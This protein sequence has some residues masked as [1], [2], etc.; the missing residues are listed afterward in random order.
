[1]HSKG[2]YRDSDGG[3]AAF[4]NRY[5]T[6]LK[7]KKVG[8]KPFDENKSADFSLHL[9]RVLA[10]CSNDEVMLLEFVQGKV[11]ILSILR[12]VEGF[13]PGF[14]S[15]LTPWTEE[16]SRNLKKMQTTVASTSKSVTDV[17]RMTTQAEYR[18]SVLAEDAMKLRL[19]LSARAM[20]FDTLGWAC[21]GTKFHSVYLRHQQRANVMADQHGEANDNLSMS[22]F[23]E[24]FGNMPEKEVVEILMAPDHHC[25]DEST[26]EVKGSSSSVVK[27][28]R[29]VCAGV[30]GEALARQ[31]ALTNDRVGSEF[32]EPSRVDRDA[33]KRGS[34]TVGEDETV[35]GETATRG[36]TTVS[37][38][39]GDEE[40]SDQSDHTTPRFD[41]PTPRNDRRSSTAFNPSRRMGYSSSAQQRADWRALPWGTRL[42]YI[43]YLVNVTPFTMREAYE[44]PY[45]LYL[46]LLQVAIPDEHLKHSLSLKSLFTFGV[47]KSTPFSALV[48]LM[49]NI[50][51]D[52]SIHDPSFG[53]WTDATMCGWLRYLVDTQGTKEQQER[54]TRVRQEFELRNSSHPSTSTKLT[55]DVITKLLIQEETR[56]SKAPT[57]TTS[58]EY[59]C[60]VVMSV[61][62]QNVVGQQKTGGPIKPK[63]K[64]KKAKPKGTT[65]APAPPEKPKTPRQKRWSGDKDQDCPTCHMW[66]KIH[67]NGC[68]YREGERPCFQ[69]RNL[70]HTRRECQLER[71]QTVSGRSDIS[72]VSYAPVSHV[73]SHKDQRDE[74]S[75][76]SGSVYSTSEESEL[77]SMEGEES[78]TMFH[79]AVSPLE[80]PNQAKSPPTHVSA[81]DHSVVIPMLGLDR[82]CAPWH[83]GGPLLGVGN[84]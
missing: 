36:E 48:D 31:N 71:R 17:D 41:D 23:F 4:K 21:K 6:D 14:Q 12:D 75:A 77:E 54:M 11:K 79:V 39:G 25:W 13:H 32:T 38:E 56:D 72:T 76:E 37:A 83:A 59:L 69:Y 45:R 65:E 10:R 64:T 84:Y 68:P 26:G 53:Q 18:E 50:L 62:G 74:E 58:S 24:L 20:A 8:V 81:R 9:T 49:K 73:A 15:R 52:M 34:E 80:A 40:V 35:A 7:R 19:I 63:G 47:I 78:S 43:N 30:L 29:V 51:V 2:S 28:P 27:N 67:P 16:V 3:L 61:V 1:M 46:E 57:T 5:A 60:P 44:C 22:S 66:M 55:F 33:Q 82:R 70:G 42:Q